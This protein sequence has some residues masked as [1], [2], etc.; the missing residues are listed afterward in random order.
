MRPLR[1]RAQALVVV[2]QVAPAAPA[3]VLVVRVPERALH[4]AVRL[5]LLPPRMCTSRRLPQDNRS[6][7][8]QYETPGRPAGQFLL[9]C[10]N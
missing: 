8:L 10:G 2:G 5:R 6:F 9:G 7:S 3:L 4:R 1:L